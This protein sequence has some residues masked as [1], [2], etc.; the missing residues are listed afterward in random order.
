MVKLLLYFNHRLSKM[1]IVVFKFW[2]TMKRLLFYSCQFY[3]FILTR[4]FEDNLKVKRKSEGLRAYLFGPKID[5]QFVAV[6]AEG[7]VRGG[8]LGERVLIRLH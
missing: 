8:L 6:I 1:I 4:P 3:S 7:D 2:C 5:K